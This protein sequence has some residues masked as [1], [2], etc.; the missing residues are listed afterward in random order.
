MIRTIAAAV[1]ALLTVALPADA[2]TLTLWNVDLKTNTNPS[3]CGAPYFCSPQET[4]TGYFQFEGNRSSGEIATWDIQASGPISF[5][6]SL[7]SSHAS[8]SD[9]GTG[10]GYASFTVG[11]PPTQP[12]WNLILDTGTSSNAVFSGTNNIPIGAFHPTYLLVSGWPTIFDPNLTVIPLSGSLD[13]GGSISET[14]LPPALPMF[15]A[16]LLALS[17]FPAYRSRRTFRG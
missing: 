5:D 3:L 17:G 1:F 7:G 4:V 12:Y 6:F 15:G 10:N 2:A 8:T 14:P 9:N 11:T 16:A 13:Y